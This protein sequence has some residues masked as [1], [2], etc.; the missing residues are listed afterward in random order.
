LARLVRWRRTDCEG[1]AVGRLESF[2][3]RSNEEPATVT[4]TRSIRVWFAID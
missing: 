3:D 4:I 1:L 2:D